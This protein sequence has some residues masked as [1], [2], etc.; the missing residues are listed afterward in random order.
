[1]MLLCASAGSSSPKALP[2]SCSYGTVW[3]V[4]AVV[5]SM[6]MRVTRAS[7]AD[8]DAS[9]AERT[10]A[11]HRAGFK[12]NTVWRIMESSGWLGRDACVSLEPVDLNVGEAVEPC[13]CGHISLF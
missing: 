8:V 3:P 6:T 12:R 5:E 1:M 4:N 9:N 11:L 10:A 13:S 2:R 7:T